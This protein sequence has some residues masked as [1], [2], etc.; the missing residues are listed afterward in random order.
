MNAGSGDGDQFD[1]FYCGKLHD[2][3]PIVVK[4][5]RATSTQ[6]IDNGELKEKLVD[7]LRMLQHPNLLRFLGV[8]YKENCLVYEDIANGSL[9]QWIAGGENRRRGFL[10]WHARLRVMAETARA[11][12][13]LHSNQLDTGDP[14]IH[15]AIKPANILLDHNFVAKICQDDRALLVSRHPNGGHATQDSIC[16][17]L[18]SN[19]QY[20]APEYLRSGVFNEK[21]DI[22]ALGVTL[23]EVLTGKFWNA[24]GI[25][26]GAMRDG[27]AF[28]NALDPNAGCWDVS[29]AWQVAELG[30]CCA[31]LD[32][33]NRPDMQQRTLAL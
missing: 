10:P 25:I 5:V 20:L 6:R 23:L 11:V 21:T 28:E 32:E 24:L 1:S 30:L 29:L 33:C 26:E 15:G 13:F 3:T 4:R 7:T 27:G 18:G 14:I 12:S 19:C 8:C 2:G 17:F 16:A 22:Y 31:S 9:K